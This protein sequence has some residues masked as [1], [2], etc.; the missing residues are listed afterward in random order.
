MK[1]FILMCLISIGAFASEV[2]D[3]KVKGMVCSFCAQGIEKNL[4][5]IETVEKVDVNLDQG[6]V[7]I[8]VKEKTDL[9]L[10]KEKIKDAG[11]LAE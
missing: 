6:K 3:L 11:Y 2:I 9:K 4:K 5:E 1:L 7:K 10:I 8:F